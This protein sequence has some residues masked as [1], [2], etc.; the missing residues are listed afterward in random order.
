MLKEQDRLKKEKKMLQEDIKKEDLIKSL[1]VITLGVIAFL[2]IAYFGMNVIKGNIK[3]G[4]EETKIDDT[5]EK[6]VIC[7]TLFNQDESEYYV[8]AYS[9]SDDDTKKIYSGVMSMYSGTI[10]QLNTDSGLNK[11]CVGE[12]LVVNN[13]ISKL[14]LTSPTLLQIK[15]KKIIKSYTTY[16]DILK[17]LSS[18]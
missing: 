2:G 14:Q 3:F 10:Y 5:V 16:E 4:K 9:F 8:L 1:V 15:D 13:D 17:V 18:N 7:G 6:A 12:K 11:S